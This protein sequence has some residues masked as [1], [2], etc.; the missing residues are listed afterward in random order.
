MDASDLS[1]VGVPDSPQDQVV[2][3]A[4]LAHSAGVA[5][6]VCSPQEVAAV[7]Q[8]I[9]NEP[10]LVVPGVRPA[11]TEGTDDQARFATPSQAIA[12]GASM[13]VV[14]RPIT[15]A[16]DPDQAARAIAATL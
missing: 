16:A 9:G 12:A 11:G 5:G 6:L 3:L 2:R 13:L 4:K 14:G 8:A 1:A 15:Q 7:R 10:L